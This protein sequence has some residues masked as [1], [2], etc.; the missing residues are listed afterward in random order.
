MMKRLLLF[1]F[2]GCLGTAHAQFDKARWAQEFNDSYQFA[3]AFELWSALAEESDSTNTARL[4]Y[5]RQASNAALKA[6]LAAEAL[7]WS[8]AL[9]QSDSVTVEDVEMHLQLLRMNSVATAIPE[10]LQGEAF[11]HLPETDINRLIAVQQNLD[12]L[13]LDSIGFEVSR[14][15]PGAKG[16]EFAAV[17]FGAGLVFQSTAVDPGIT[18]RKDGWSGKYFT[19]LMFIPDTNVAEP[20]FSVKQQ[21]K[22]EDLFT[23]FGHARTHD[24]PVAFDTEQDF[25][26]ITRNQSALDSTT[27]VRLSHLRLEFFWKREWG[28]EPARDFPWNS[29]QYSCGHGTFDTEG[30]LIFMS[31]MPGGYG[32]MDLY[33]TRWED[34]DWS[35]PENLGP[36]VNTGGNESFP[37][38]SRSGFL[39]F[40]SDGHPGMGG[41]DVFVHP[42]GSNHVER[43]GTPINSVADDFAL[44]LD[45]SSGNGWMSSNRDNQTDAI[46]S[47]RGKPMTGSIQISVQACDGS[48]VAGATVNVIDERHGTVQSYAT[49]E[50]GEVKAYG[51]LG[52]EY[53]INMESFP[54]MD[55]PPSQQLSLQGASEQVL[56]DMNFASKQNSLVVI[57]ENGMPTEG[58]LLTF[59]DAAGESA[60]FVTDANGR[61]TWSAASQSEDYVQVKTVLINYNDVIHEFTPPPPGCLLSIADTLELEPWTADVERIDLANI[62]YDLGSAALRMESKRELD[63][64]VA[65]MK[66]RPGIRVELSSHTD[67]RNDERHNQK[68]SQDRAD[69]CV[70]YIIQK[71]IGPERIL[72][73][74]YGESRL[75]NACSDES[76]CGCA[77]LN[78][79]GCVPCSE[80]LH[81][82]NR[83]TELRLLAD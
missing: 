24:G 68:L 60:N 37:H 83:R 32:G 78:V 15:R 65:Y 80:E 51:W 40:S 35:R 45:E 47:V 2:F 26:V 66:D 14:Y 39:Y 71:G 4:H 70:A 43:L 52:R 13:V 53:E 10:L 34:G 38:V 20:R 56:L 23:A 49:D 36:A 58:V 6:G 75:L 16:N 82:Q 54:G 1:L 30:D 63:K 64:L 42:L 44:V 48:A 61:Y 62:L 9:V 17:P 21:L 25:A 12:R 29:S 77:P 33:Q 46:F 11:L 19:E 69:G 79:I 31:D 81:Q 27:E 67:C 57:D 73:K 55:A 7:Q 3:R 41:M 76:T 5:I 59:Q 22:G 50:E 72:A 18:P 8:Q 74:G 28:W